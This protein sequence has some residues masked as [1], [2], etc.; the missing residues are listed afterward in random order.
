[1]WSEKAG[2]MNASLVDAASGAADAT[3]ELALDVEFVGPT[4][5]RM[6]S[7]ALIP[8]GSVPGADA[9]PVRRVD[10]EVA[11]TPTAQGHVARVRA[12]V[13]LPKAGDYQVVVGNPFTGKGISAAQQLFQVV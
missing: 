6:L 1:M 8:E 4:P 12:P 10:T 2:D 3:V 7:V 11:W 9:W 5:P 13:R